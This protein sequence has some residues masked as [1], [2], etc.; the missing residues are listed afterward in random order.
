MKIGVFGGTFNPIHLSHIHLAQQF[1]VELALDKVLIVPTYTPP[2]KKTKGL[3]C[4]NDRLEM[5][6]LAIE[7]FPLFEVC[8]YEVEQQGKSFTFRTLGHLQQVYPDAEFYLLMGADMFLTVQDWRQPQEIYRIATLCAAER[9]SG[10]L[11]LL[12]AHRQILEM[13]GARCKIIDLEAKPLSSTMVREV[14]KSGQDVSALLDPKVWE[15]IVKHKLYK[16]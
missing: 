13:Q 6:R 7:S 3:A 5:C 8:G 12:E 1:A 16:K 15:Y 9:E 4:S 11:T 2:H 10:E 14:I